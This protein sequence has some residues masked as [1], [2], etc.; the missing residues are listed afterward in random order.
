MTNRDNILNELSL[1][2]SS[3]TSL[4]PENVYKVPAGYF[5]AFAEKMLELV[6][7]V[8]AEDSNHLTGISKELPYSVP[9]NYFEGLEER[10]M[11]VVRE[12]ADYQTVQEELESISPLLSSLPKQNPYVV[13]QGYFDSIGERNAPVKIIS[14]THRKWFRYAA[15]AVVIGIVTL[16]AIFFING[17]AKPVG[18]DKAWAKVEKKVEKF[19]DEEIKDFIEFNDAGLS[20]S[21]TAGLEPVKKEELRE[22][23][24][25]VSD[26]E[27]KEFL[28]QTSDGLDD[29]SLLN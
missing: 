19:S 20:T 23:L 6:K 29:I 9:Q 14:I 8:P 24:K 3:L 1:L 4:A 15:A 10:L 25:D 27:L 28:E 21:E 13:P 17:K 26:S 2:N 18:E 5:E 11:Q 7:T 16:G 12:R 22:L